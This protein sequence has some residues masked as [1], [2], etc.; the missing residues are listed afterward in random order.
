MWDKKNV[1]NILRFYVQKTENFD[2]V[3]TK[4]SNRKEYM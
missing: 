3:H 2:I 1:R 4:I